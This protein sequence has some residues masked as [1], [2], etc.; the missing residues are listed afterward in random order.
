MADDDAAFAAAELDEDAPIRNVVILMKENRS[1]DSY[2]GMLGRG[3]GFALDPHGRPTNTNPDREG[4]LVHAHRLALPGQPSLERCQS[5]DASHLAWNGGAMDSFVSTCGSE[6]PMS[7]LDGSDLPWYYSLARTFGIA[8]RYFASCLGEGAANR[9][10]L[11]AATADG[12]IGRSLASPFV[13]P[14]RSGLIWDRLEAAGVPWANYYVDVPELALWPRAAVRYSERLHEFDAFLKDCANGSLPAVSLVTPELAGASDGAYEDD[15]L[16]EAFCATV[17]DAVL[18]SPQW[19][20]MLFVLT[21]DCAGG[22]YDH[23]PPPAAVP[24]DEVPPGA[25]VPP[26]QPGGYDRYGFRVGCVVASPFSKPAHV[27]SVVYDHASIL[28]TIEQNWH[29]RPL[30]RRDAAAAPLWDFLDLGASPSFSVPPVLPRPA[31]WPPPD[32]F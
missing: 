15:R 29:L 1:Y 9:R 27:S 20:G 30:T 17:F 32:Q 14:P 24:P 23:V 4:S 13:R 26:A 2:F 11:Q 5:W 6:D 19:P 25:P 12:L 28:A 18:A 3:D 16:G 10:F 31:I 21:W 7:Y 8:D 22:F